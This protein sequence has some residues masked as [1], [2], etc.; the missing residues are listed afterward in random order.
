MTD[1]EREFLKPETRDGFYVD[2]DR[3]ALFWALLGI[4]KEIDRICQNNSIRYFASFGTLLGA[5]RHKGFIP[6]DDDVDLMMPRADYNKFLEVAPKE[7]QD[8][9]FL[10]TTLSEHEFVGGWARVRNSNTTATEKGRVDLRSHINMGLWAAIFPIDSCPIDCADE[11][12]WR[13]LSRV[14]I[15]NALFEHAYVRRRCCGVKSWMLSLVLRCFLNIVGVRRIIAY[16]EHCCAAYEK[17]ESTF[18]TFFTRLHNYRELRVSHN[19]F[20]KPVMMPFEDMMIPVPIGY[21]E[22]LK[23]MYGDWRKFV[24]GTACHSYEDLDVTTPYKRYVTKKYGY[25]P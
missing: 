12:A 8:P 4:I 7:L 2:A 20:A 3:K 16:R 23:S 9:Y 22:I 14:Y 24:T 10:Q 17:S 6:W 21:D 13:V 25:T 11:I 19:A 15:V 18:A 5:V 1:R